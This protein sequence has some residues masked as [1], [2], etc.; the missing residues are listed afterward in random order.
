ML[1]GVSQL[2]KDNLVPAG[3]ALTASLGYN[4]YYVR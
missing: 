3:L 1:A 4:R 2:C